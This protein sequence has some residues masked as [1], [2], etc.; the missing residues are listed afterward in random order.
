MPGKTGR[1]EDTH[2]ISVKKDGANHIAKE[3]WV[4]GDRE[5][6]KEELEE[7]V[8]ARAEQIKHHLNGDICPVC[9]SNH[10]HD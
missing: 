9:G 8:R 5:Q 3:C 2:V 10:E 7:G 4:I 6:T 1:P